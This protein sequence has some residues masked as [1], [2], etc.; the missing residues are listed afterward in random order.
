MS[1][2]DCY[3]ILQLKQG[4]SPDEVKAAF[5]KLAFKLHPD[6]NPSPD[7]AERFRKVNEAY[8]LLNRHLEEEIAA[9]RGFGKSKKE[10]EEPKT[11]KAEGARAYA[12]Q[13]AGARKKASKGPTTG[14]WSRAGKGPNTGPRA[15]AKYSS[16]RFYFREEE[17][18]KDILKDE[19]ARQVYEDIYAEIRGKNPRAAGRK[20]PLKHKKMRLKWGEKSVELDLSKGVKGSVKSWFRSQLDHDQ[21]VFF[22]ANSLFPG[23]TI[24][25]SIDQRFTKGPRTVDVTLPPDFVIGRPIRLKGL[26]RKLGPLR[27][28]LYLRVFAK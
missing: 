3:R 14:A 25:I 11:S 2:R 21:D 20:G 28:D 8:V 4:A 13:Q 6:L 5:R 22:P 17:V 23:R 16:K 1:I 10:Q 9:G 15:D 26:G 7:A 12:R 19:F 24:R 18:L 27:G